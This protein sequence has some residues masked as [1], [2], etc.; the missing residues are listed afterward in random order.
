MTRSEILEKA[1]EIVNG[2]RQNSYG[3]PEDNFAIIADLWTTYMG[4]MVQ[5]TAEDVS[6]MMILLKVAR[7]ATGTGSDDCY[8]DIA[9]Y[10]AC[11]AELA[12]KRIK[13]GL[14]E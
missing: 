7:V 6:V 12:A 14:Y 11:G 13:G 10:A 3:D 8:V 5:F 9:G 4:H 1:K 2:E